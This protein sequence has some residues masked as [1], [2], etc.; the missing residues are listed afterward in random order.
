MAHGNKK[1]FHVLRQRRLACEN[2]HLLAKTEFNPEAYKMT[3]QLNLF[4]EVS[5]Q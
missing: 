2:S 3:N 5:G 1:D 4:N